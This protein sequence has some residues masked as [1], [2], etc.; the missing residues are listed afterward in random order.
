VIACV[1]AVVA[2]M[3]LHAGDP[4]AAAPV[5]KARVASAVWDGLAAHERT[6][7]IV[8]Y[9]DTAPAPAPSADLDGARHTA[10][11]VASD[12]VLA[13][14]PAGSYDRVQRVSNW[15]MVALDADRDAVAA[16]AASPDV[17][18]VSP[19]L[20]HPP[21]LAQSVPAIGGPVAYAA[22][23]TGA[24]QTVAILDTGV[25][26]T[27]PFFGGRVVA[28]ACFSS[29]TGSSTAICPGADPTTA[30]GPGSAAPCPA[31]QCEHG[32]HVAG[33]AAGNNGTFNGVAKAAN[34]I[35]VQVFSS[36]SPDACGRITPCAMYT[37]FDL[38][39]G[40]D[41][42]FGLRST[43]HIAAANMSLGGFFSPG[44][45]DFSP[46]ERP[47]SDLRS[48]GIAPVVAAGND[49]LKDSLALP[50]CASNAVSVGATDKVTNAVAGFSNS[51]PFLTLLAPGID[52]TSSLPG[53]KYGSLSGTS[54]ATPHITGSFALLKQQHP[55]W[56]VDDITSLLRATGLPVTD[57]G[58][59]L[60]VPRVRLDGAVRPPTYHPIA[61]QRIF[62]SR[63]TNSPLGE[64][65]EVRVAVPTNIGVPGSASAVLVTVTGIGPSDDTH[66][67]VW[68][69]GFPMPITSNVNLATGDV[70]AGTTVA[71]LGDGHRLSIFNQSGEVHVAV[72]VVGW[73]DDGGDDDNGTRFVP[74]APTRVL[75]TRA[76]TGGVPIA[77][78]GPGASVAFPVA[79]KC[80]ASTTA[81]ALNVTMTG[82]T[83]ETHF[84]VYP[85][86]PVQTSFSSLNAPAHATRANFTVSLIG[87]GGKVAI[88]NNT[89]SA[90][91]VV[92]LYGCYTS[93]PAPGTGRFVPI[94]PARI[95]DTRAGLGVVRPG[96]LSGAGFQANAFQVTGRGGVPSSGVRAAIVN[97]TV[98]DNDADTHLSVSPSGIDLAQAIQALGASAINA[99]AGETVANVVEV[100]LGPDGKFLVKTNA[101]STDLVVDVLGW[102]S[103]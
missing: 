79:D 18:A 15:P 71:K 6:P 35:A 72:D 46:E 78:I 51:D 54:M 20:A 24:G 44:P 41:F 42:V 94:E 73:V 8:T 7:V 37:D 97:L 92:D 52:I 76:G 87:T 12:H 16:L 86:G 99:S 21:A 36:F 1:G 45:C 61:G 65:D 102:I 103:D 75:D 43:F 91:A 34:I 14:L 67:T 95:V 85:S 30:T 57:P 101:G 63:D 96:K 22:G 27:H 10:L 89:G 84:T 81:V 28:Q 25:D 69:T 59:D 64:R 77:P 2:V 48:A 5:V 50:A 55:T 60:T 17:V 23:F 80:P 93:S 56:S 26:A 100:Q 68:P 9:R 19:N 70:R 62:D 13:G 49:S 88:R 33:I 53:N 31:F 58:N 29:T 83:Q 40:L 11:G 38:V 90:H 4:A 32:T 47:F 66:L 39:R 98:T 3:V 82:P 74:T